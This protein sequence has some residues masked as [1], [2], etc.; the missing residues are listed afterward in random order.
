M[1]VTNPENRVLIETRDLEPFHSIEKNRVVHPQCRVSLILKNCDFFIFSL[2]KAYF[3][4]KNTHFWKFK[5]PRPPPPLFRNHLIGG[6]CALSIKDPLQAVDGYDNCYTLST[7][8]TAV[9]MGE[10]IFDIIKR[11]WN[12]DFSPRRVEV[13]HLS[14]IDLNFRTGDKGFVTG[15][16]SLITAG[17]YT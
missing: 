6:R 13:N 12:F 3:K 14:T 1:L 7:A 16:E 2:K 10:G 4:A 11:S 15:C 8:V 5:S 17:S 9:T